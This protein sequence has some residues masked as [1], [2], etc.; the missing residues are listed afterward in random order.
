[1][2]SRTVVRIV[3]FRDPRS[4]TFVHKGKTNATLLATEEGKSMA[5]DLRADPVLVPFEPSLKFT[6]EYEI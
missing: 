1:M 2:D 3:S 5:S 4:T 6:V